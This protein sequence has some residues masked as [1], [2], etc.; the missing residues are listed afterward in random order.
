MNFMIP[1]HDDG[2]VEPRFGRAPKV[3]VAT[4]DDSGSITGW[5]TFDVQWDR[6]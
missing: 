4:V 5:Q 1:V 6:L 2:S 3:A